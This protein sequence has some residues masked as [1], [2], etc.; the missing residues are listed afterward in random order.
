MQG[1]N[2]KMNQM[3][4]N[5]SLIFSLMSLSAVSFANEVQKS[6]DVADAK[7]T[8]TIPQEPAVKLLTKEEIEQGLADMRA[9]MNNRIEAWGNQLTRR[10]FDR[11]KGK[12]V[13]KKTKQLE[14][15]QI[16]QGVI[17]ET[18]TSAQQNKNRLT[19]EDQKLVEQREKFIQAIG[20]KNNIIPTKL[21]FDCR[22]K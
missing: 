15:C 7:V 12:L 16:F 22:V 11:N 19:V 5:A 6:N 13:L 18:Y 14:V 4:L 17:D 10:D 21:G 2:I 1:L 3:I 8:E 9:K 20:V